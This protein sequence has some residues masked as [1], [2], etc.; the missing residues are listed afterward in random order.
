MVRAPG[1][2]TTVIST[3]VGATSAST[4]APTARAHARTAQQT[5]TRSSYPSRAINCGG[6]D[7]E[8]GRPYKASPMQLLLIP[9][10]VPRADHL[11][12]QYDKL[13]ALLDKKDRL[14]MRGSEGE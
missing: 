1:V 13:R 10:D 9:S 14:S 11:L 8:L 4:A 6:H 5:G 7:D 12:K 3:A 2:R